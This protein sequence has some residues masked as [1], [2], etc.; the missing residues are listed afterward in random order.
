M[1][2]AAAS[3]AAMVVALGAESR[4]DTA[5]RR[6]GSTANRAI[7]P[8]S[9]RLL[10]R[11]VSCR[12]WGPHNLQWQ[13]KITAKLYKLSEHGRFPLALVTTPR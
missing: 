2:S 13:Q 10:K 8:P 4:A 11:S 9:T 12:A 1:V 6:Q 7:L 3:A 5:D